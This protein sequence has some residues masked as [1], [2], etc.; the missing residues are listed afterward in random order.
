MRFGDLRIMMASAATL[1][2]AS[3]CEGAGMNWDKASWDQGRGVYDGANPRLDMATKLEAAGIRAGT[4]RA[5]VR[6]LLG[7]P[8]RK[9]ETSDNWY[10]GRDNLAPDII[11]LKV[12]YDQ[13]RAVTGV[14]QVRS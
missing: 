14:E 10:L 13:R 5:E 8:D 11:V 6:D 9:G 1:V 2:I 4:S 3:G 7:E 12:M